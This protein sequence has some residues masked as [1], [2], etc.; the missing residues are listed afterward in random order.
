M[1]VVYDY[2]PTFRVRNFILLLFSLAWGVYSD[3]VFSKAFKGN[4]ASRDRS[5]ESRVGVKRVLRGI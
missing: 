1:K 2:E 3:P 5:G 4:E